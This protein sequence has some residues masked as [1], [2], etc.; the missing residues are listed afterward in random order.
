[1]MK[2]VFVFQGVENYNF[3]S[4]TSLAN[5]NMYTAHFGTDTI[6]NLGPK[7]RKPV[8]DEIKNASP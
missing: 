4:G 5:R 7:L 1:M 6:T 3:R 8:P 2:E